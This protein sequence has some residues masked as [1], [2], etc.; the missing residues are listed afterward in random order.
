MVAEIFTSDKRSVWCTIPDHDENECCEICVHAKD[1]HPIT[2]ENGTKNTEPAPKYDPRR[3]FRKGD[4]VQEVLVNG[5]RFQGGH[6]NH[7]AGELATVVWNENN[8]TSTMLQYE[9]GDKYLIDVAYLELITPVE[10]LEPYF[11]EYDKDIMEEWQVCK[12]ITD[13]A[14][15]PVVTFTEF[16][17]NAKEAAQAERDRLNAEYRKEV[18]Q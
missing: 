3:K 15:F 7:K 6:N 13:T 9:D 16:Y 5:R 1:L 17:P 18:Q 10:E 12:R 2:P 8:N 4:K 14:S 11:V